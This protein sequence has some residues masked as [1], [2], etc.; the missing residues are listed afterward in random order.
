MPELTFISLFSGIGGIDL[1]FERAGMK[2]ALQVEIDDKCSD[3][4]KRHW[5]DVP[6]LGDVNNVGRDAGPVDLICGGFPC[7]PVSAAGKRKGKADA[8]WLWPEFNRIVRKVRPRY[9]LVENVP[10]LL[11]TDSGRLM[12][13]VLGDLALC[14][15]DAEWDC[16]SAASVGAWHRRDRIFIVA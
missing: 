12:G 13:E 15:Y 8:R 11:S 5:P 16:V 1:G 3:I 10:G 14:G 6:N 2:C 9:V 4:L 7:Q